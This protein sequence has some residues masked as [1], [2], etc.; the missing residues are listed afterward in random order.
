MAPAGLRASNRLH[1]PYRTRRSEES[2]SR[3]WSNWQRNRTK[4]SGKEGGYESISRARLG[5]TRWWERSTS[6]AITRASSSRRCS[7]RRTAARSW[8][9]TTSRA[10]RSTNG[11]SVCDVA[12]RKSAGRCGA[13]LLVLARSNQPDQNRRFV[14]DLAEKIREESERRR[15]SGQPDL[16]GYVGATYPDLSV[17]VLGRGARFTFQPA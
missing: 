7:R 5:C 3:N 16:V 14:D 2:C 10:S 8:R 4:S 1:W 12:P 9:R 15:S 11:S 6:S 17:L 13:S